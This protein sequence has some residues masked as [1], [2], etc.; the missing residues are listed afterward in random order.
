[1]S[2]LIAKLNFRNDVPTMADQAMGLHSL[3]DTELG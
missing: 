1:M 2:K 3:S